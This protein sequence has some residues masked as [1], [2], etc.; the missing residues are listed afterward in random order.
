MT[1]GL[2]YNAQ[3]RASKENQVSILRNGCRRISVV[4]GLSV[5]CIVSGGMETDGER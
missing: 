4:K 5:K 1:V 2:A 3:L